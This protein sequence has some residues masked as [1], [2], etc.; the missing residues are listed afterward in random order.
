[1]ALVLE[2]DKGSDIFISSWDGR[3]WSAPEPIATIN[4]DSNERGPAF[5]SSG[6]YLYFSSDRKGGQ[7]GYDI[8]EA[9]WNG[10][11]WTSVRSLGPS[12]NGPSNETGPALSSDDSMLYF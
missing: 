9:L 12:V 4:T 1:M 5:S 7:G 11:E 2:R 6:N 8:Y 3:V 10:S